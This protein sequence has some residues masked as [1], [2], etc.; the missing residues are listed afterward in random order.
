MVPR[1]SGDNVWTPAFAGATLQETFY[2][3]I[4]IEKKNSSFRN[5]PLAGDLGPRLF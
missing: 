2:E 3:I 1:F 4:K 5:N